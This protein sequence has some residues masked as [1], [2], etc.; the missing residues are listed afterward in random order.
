MLL[1]RGV[2]ITALSVLV[3]VIFQNVEFLIEVEIRIL[4]AEVAHESMLV[5]AN[6]RAGQAAVLGQA[7]RRN[8][9]VR[10]PRPVVFGGAAELHAI[11][12]R[13]GGLHLD[14][15]ASPMSSAVGSP[16]RK[17]LTKTNTET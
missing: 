12:G 2:V 11:S 4:P 13:D 15:N 9:A 1:E 8:A 14:I 6:V 10:Q 7:L 17:D 16:V 5:V 3:K